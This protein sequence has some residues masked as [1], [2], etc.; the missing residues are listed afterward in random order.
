LSTASRTSIAQHSSS[1]PMGSYYH[2]ESTFSCRL[3]ANSL[4]E[5][6]IVKLFFDLPN[7]R[8]SGSAN[9]G[10]ALLAIAAR[11]SNTWMAQLATRKRSPK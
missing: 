5:V 7:P 4:S 8:L 6:R 1:G 9:G 10:S 11:C 2:F 3:A